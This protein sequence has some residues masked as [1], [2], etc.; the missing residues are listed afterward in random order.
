M[1]VKDKMIGNFQDTEID[2]KMLSENSSEEDSQPAPTLSS[3]E[4]IGSVDSNAISIEMAP[5]TLSP[6]YGSIDDPDDL[7]DDYDN[8]TMDNDESKEDNEGN[9]ENFNV[10]EI[11]TEANSIIDHNNKKNLVLETHDDQMMSDVETCPENIFEDT[12]VEDSNKD[13]ERESD[14]DELEQDEDVE[15]VDTKEESNGSQDYQREVDLDNPPQN[16]NSLEQVEN[17]QSNPESLKKDESEAASSEQV[18]TI[19]L[20]LTPTTHVFPFPTIQLP[21]V[22]LPQQ[23]ATE[24]PNRSPLQSPAPSSPSETPKPVEK[25]DV[26]QTSDLSL[27]DIDPSILPTNFTNIS[28]KKENARPTA[29][30]NKNRPPIGSVN[31]QRSYEICKAVVE[32][33]ANR[34]KVE[35]QLVPPPAKQKKLTHTI[36]DSQTRMPVSLPPGATIVVASSSQ[37]GKT[38]TFAPRLA[39]GPQI[40]FRGLRPQLPGVSGL[41]VRLPPTAVPISPQ[42]FFAKNINSNFTP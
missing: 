25:P 4:P 39:V 19:P 21:T 27:N 36:L 40:A 23:E 42:Q 13:D 31:L 22:P 29:I 16:T 10:E 34:A 26:D 14:E 24:S 11:H 28:A 5:P 30:T 9:I 41:R 6:N 3:E 2:M 17:S 37:Q 1:G 7:S 18:A 38:L 12:E 33:S 15:S 35:N 32:K 8:D 20:L